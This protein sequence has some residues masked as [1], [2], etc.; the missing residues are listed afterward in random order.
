LPDLNRFDTIVKEELAKLRESEVPEDSEANGFVKFESLITNWADAVRHYES[1]LA[2][3]PT[4][5]SARQNRSLTVTYL[6][7]LAEL[8]KQEEEDTE[9]SMQQA[10]PGEGP[11]E[12][13]EG[14]EEGEEGEG[15]PKEGKGKGKKQPG[16]EG[17]GEED[18]KDGEGD[19]G[20]EKKDGKKGDD[21]DEKDGDKGG[22]NPNESPED[23]A[24]RIL[25]ENADREVG[26]LSPGRREFR[27]AKEDW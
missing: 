24:H 17:E 25:K 12:E 16:E 10:Q 20:D 13:G 21:G 27:D 11:P 2:L 14:E 9:Q 19:D 15:E 3:Q 23:R 26:P 18:P 5:R 7:R 6:N 8:L 1:T 4:D 22:D